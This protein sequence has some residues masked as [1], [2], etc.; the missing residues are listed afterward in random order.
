MHRQKGNKK[1]NEIPK[2]V[3]ILN[4]H[5]ASDN[6]ENFIEFQ[7]LKNGKSHIIR[8]SGFIQRYGDEALKEFE[9]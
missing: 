8:E 3:K 6:H 2:E 4:I 5:K 7:L 9:K 1:M